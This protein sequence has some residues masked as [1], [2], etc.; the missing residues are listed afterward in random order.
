MVC[1]ECGFQLMK[2]YS[3][4][5]TS[6]SYFQLLPLAFRR[7]GEGTVFTGVCLF[8]FPGDTPI[9]LM[10][11]YP[12]LADRG[13]PHPV[14]WGYPCLADRGVPH[15]TEGYPWPGLDRGV[16]PPSQL[17]M[18]SRGVLDTRCAVFL[19]L[20]RRRTFLL[21]RYHHV[22]LCVSLGF[23]WK[24]PFVPP[25]GLTVPNNLIGII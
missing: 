5:H 13:V 2:R 17:R 25:L 7:N 3:S 6:Y 16:P 8:T 20:S 23:L 1:L 19:V 9:L 21:T 10:E 14:D 11:G 24:R 22:T 12:H 18:N 4:I 15:P